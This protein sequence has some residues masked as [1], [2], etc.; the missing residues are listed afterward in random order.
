MSEKFLSGR[1]RVRRLAKNDDSCGWINLLP[2]RRQATR[3]SGTKRVEW[4]VIGA[5]MFGL[6]AAI[7]LAELYPGKSIALIDAQRAGECSAGRNSGFAVGISPPRGVDL[8]TAN[9]AAMVARMKGSY[10]VNKH[11]Q[12]YLKDLI[13]KNGIRCEWDETGKIHAAV[14]RRYEPS[15]D[16]FSMILDDLGIPN[17]RLNAEDL[18]TRLGTSYYK[19]GLWTGETSLVQPAALA[20]G[21]ADAASKTV[22]LYEETRVQEISYGNVVTIKCAEGTLV[23]DKIIVATNGLLGEFGI[24]KRRSMH[25]LLTS[26][27]TRPLTYDERSH[28]GAVEPWGLLS[29]SPLGPT[30]RYTPDHRLMLRS[31]SEFWPRLSMSRQELRKRSPIYDTAIKARWPVLADIPLD[32]VW[33]GVIA[34]SGN[35]APVFAQLAPNVF[36]IGLCNASGLS[37]GA[38]FGKLIVDHV[39]GVDSPALSIVR[40]TATPTPLPP[41]PFLDIG[42]AVQMA[43]TRRT[44]G[45]C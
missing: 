33:S 25:F 27:L 21:L 4:A 6:T 11:G 35:A 26:C 45:E 30:V 14:S 36:A 3:L 32:Y 10:V 19:D 22:E 2:S 1:F 28:I 24:L 41:R 43:R 29:M 15:L 5:G 44:A 37:R 8:A 9:R 17:R 38:A 40:K 31:T 42:V 7:R 39:A 23:A 16:G 20:R 18:K 12:L 13:D 34:I